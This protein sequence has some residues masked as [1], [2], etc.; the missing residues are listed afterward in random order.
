MHLT[1]RKRTESK[2]LA[3]KTSKTLIKPNRHPLETQKRT[4]STTLEKRC[5]VQ[6]LCALFH[7]RGARDFCALCRTI[8]RCPGKSPRS[9][10]RLKSHYAAVNGQIGRASCRERV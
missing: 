9:R 8:R 5:Q 1:P 3:G 7:G 2:A 10:H 6:G 4:E